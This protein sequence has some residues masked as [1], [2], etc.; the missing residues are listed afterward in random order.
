[1]AHGLGEDGAG[2][3][4]ESPH[5]APLGMVDGP[6]WWAEREGSCVMA[7]FLRGSLTRGWR[8][9]CEGAGVA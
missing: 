8:C 2:L 6:G 1:V 4:G 3:L 5:A 9:L 7:F